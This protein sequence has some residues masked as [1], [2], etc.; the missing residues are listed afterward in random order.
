MTQ[1]I[2]LASKG[3]Y[4]TAPAAN[5]AAVF[6]LSGNII[7]S[8]KRITAAEPCA[9][10]LQAQHLLQSGQ[11]CDSVYLTS[12]PSAEQ[13]NAF[14]ALGVKQ[15]YIA[16]LL[17]PHQVSWRTLCQQGNIAVYCGIKEDEARAL[18]HDLLFRRQHG[19][20]FVRLKLAASLD[21]R[22][23]L[24]NGQSKWITS[25]EARAD[26]QLF[27]AKS[28][29]ILSGSG[30]VIADN[31]SLNVRWSELTPLHDLFDQAQ[32]RQ[33][34][35]VIIDN[36]QQLDARYQLFDLPGDTYLVSSTPHHLAAKS[37][38]INEVNGHIDLTQLMQQL[39][40]LSFN[41]VWVEAGK[42]L[43]GA[44]FSAGLVDEFI[45]YQAP[46]LMGS[47]SRGLVDLPLYT[48]MDQVPELE[49]K[50]VDLIGPDLRLI[51]VPKH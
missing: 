41:S 2:T 8:S 15:L 6:S 44:L 34:A 18:N 19:R 22:T 24:A 17:E 37:L 31:P 46:K 40:E 43:A 38:V 9:I 25:S 10:L 27:R 49:L 47:S 50:Q 13:V 33:P 3:A 30:T 11:P 39:G 12:E 1:A 28:D 42:T 23:A 5:F 45:L 21:G 48:Q 4:T 51:S 32:L 16:S 36:R 26:V 29:V 20:P 35:R 7:A 14:A